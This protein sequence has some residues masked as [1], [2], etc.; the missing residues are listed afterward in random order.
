MGPS[1]SVLTHALPATR[2]PAETKLRD[3]PSSSSRR[4]CPGDY[5]PIGIPAATPET[6]PEHL[7]SRRV[8]TLDGS[9]WDLDSDDKAECAAVCPVCQPDQA[10][11]C[12]SPPIVATK[13][14]YAVR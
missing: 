12:C 4:P 7:N 6:T 13:R 5:L 8:D 14:S 9:D 2:L 11:M 10:T 3:R 1:A